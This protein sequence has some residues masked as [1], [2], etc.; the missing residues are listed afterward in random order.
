MDYITRDYKSL[1]QTRRRKIMSTF[2]LTSKWK[3]ILSLWQFI[4]ISLVLVPAIYFIRFF[5]IFYLAIG[6]FSFLFSVYSLDKERIVVTEKGIEYRRWFYAFLTIN[7]NW[8]DFDEIGWYG[9]REGLFIDKESITQFTPHHL[10]V[11]YWGLGR[12]AFI[13]L[14]VFSNVWRNSEIGHAIKKHAPHL[15]EE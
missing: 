12:S 10:F 13:P 2:Y 5:S 1:R 9:F 11:T 4:L 6:I 8:T 15:F 7:V 3:I 14:S